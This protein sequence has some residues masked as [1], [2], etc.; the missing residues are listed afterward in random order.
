VKKE[1]RKEGKKMNQRKRGEVFMFFLICSCKR[2][3]KNHGPPSSPEN[4][5]FTKKVI[6]LPRTSDFN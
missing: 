1:R 5:H 6:I 4:A 2:G 3:L